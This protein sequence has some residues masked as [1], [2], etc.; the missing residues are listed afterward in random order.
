M[1]FRAINGLQKLTQP[2]SGSFAFQEGQQVLRQQGFVLERKLVGTWLDKEVERIDHCHVGD[3]VDRNA[4]LANFLGKDD[5]CLEVAVRVLL[6]IDEVIGRLN[7]ERVTQDRRPAMRC[8][9]QSHHL[10]PQRGR[11]SVAIVSLMIERD[12]NC[13]ACILFDAERFK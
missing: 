1:P 5:S 4:Q 13:H 9:P 7:L 11:S 8:R 3:Q 12:A 2:R 6:P 10:W